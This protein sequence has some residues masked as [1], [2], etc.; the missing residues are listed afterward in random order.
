MRCAGCDIGAYLT[1]GFCC[2]EGFYHDILL[3]SC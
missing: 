1:N 2:A 3:G